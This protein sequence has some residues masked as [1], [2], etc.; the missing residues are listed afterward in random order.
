MLLSVSLALLVQA[1][2]GKDVGDQ[3]KIDGTGLV[4]RNGGVQI[5]DAANRGTYGLMS[6]PALTRATSG[7]LFTGKSPDCLVLVFD[8]K[9]RGRIFRAANLEVIPPTGTLV[10][11]D[12]LSLSKLTNSEA[13]R[14][15]ELIGIQALNDPQVCASA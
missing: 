10:E 7:D 15:I 14:R 6:S 12:Q 2:S 4:F 5:I 13:A 3:I 1:C 8:A 11:A 9:A